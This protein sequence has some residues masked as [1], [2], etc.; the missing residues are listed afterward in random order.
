MHLRA[1]G[2]FFP[3]FSYPVF[4]VP[5]LHFPGFSLRSPQ[6]RLRPPRENAFFSCSPHEPPPTTAE[7][8][9]PKSQPPFFSRVSLRAVPP[10]FFPPSP[11]PSCLASHSL[12]PFPALDSRRPEPCRHPPIPPSCPVPH[13][14]RPLI[15]HG[16]PFLFI[17]PSSPARLPR[18]SAP[19]F[20]FSPLFEKIFLFLLTL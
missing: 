9:T 12:T 17:P 11:C 3:F 6:R 20:P 8:P 15:S 14:A 10:L 13:P 18:L 4:P 1:S 7:R 16:F 2:L 5:C 19:C